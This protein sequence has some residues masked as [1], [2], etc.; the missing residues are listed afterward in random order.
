[1]YVILGATGHVGSAC[2]R[3]LR[4]HDRP[5]LAVV[6]DDA[7]AAAA[8]DQGADAV[9]ADIGNA[10]A[11]GQAF[12]RGHRAFLLNPPAAPDT[13]TDAEERRTVR[14]ML[15]AL[16]GSGLEKVVAESTM[17]AQP[18]ERL[19]DLSVLWDLEAGLR[20][21]SIP[22]A[23]NRAAY[24]YANFDPQLDAIRTTGQFQTMFPPDFVLPMVAPADLGRIA[25]RRLMSDADDVGVVNI[26]G[27]ERYSFG[28]VARTMAR[29]LGRDVELIT[30]PRSDW[31]SAFESLGFS[32]A[33]AQAYARI[34]GAALDDPV[35]PE[36]ETEKG[37][38]T[39]E[40]YLRSALAPP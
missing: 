7:G 5:V 11:L 35:L 30:T 19:G 26:E 29:V 28:E 24:Y 10:R 14:A 27:P 8:R 21:Q 34:T 13:D 18:G 38:V 15:E 22:A 39:L 32:P 33:A 37:T 9:V 20:S 6:H 36:R 1:M 23:I 12:K 25:A 3:E 4:A 40:S 31:E 16:D 2:V 17:G